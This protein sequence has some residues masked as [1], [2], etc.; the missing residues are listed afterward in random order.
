M[1]GLT[2]VYSVHHDNQEILS[3]ITRKILTKKLISEHQ[4][5]NLLQISDFTEWTREEIGE[6]GKS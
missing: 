6:H 3:S 4:F 5:G 2:V 1:T